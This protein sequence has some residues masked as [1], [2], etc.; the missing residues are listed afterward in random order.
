MMNQVQDILGVSLGMIILDAIQIPNKPRL[1]D[2]IGGSGS[3][4]TLGQ[5]LFATRPAC[6][7]CLII[8]GD[9]FP[10]AVEAELGNLGVTLVV[11]KRE[12]VL[13]TRGL[14]EYEDDTFGREYSRKCCETMLN[15]S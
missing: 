8:A 5:R 3:Y 2:V 9:D 15:D 12:N 14:L 13:S 10:K 1:H 11:R 6:I 4:V 7:G